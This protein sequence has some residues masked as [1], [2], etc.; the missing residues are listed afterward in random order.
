M[1]R[2]SRGGC[3]VV[4][5]L[6]VLREVR[7]LTKIRSRFRSFERFRGATL[8]HESF[9]R[10]AVPGGAQ[11]RRATYPSPRR[12]HC[13]R[14]CANLYLIKYEIDSYALRDHLRRAGRG[15]FARVR[16]RRDADGAIRCGTGIWSAKGA[17][18]YLHLR[19]ASVSRISGHVRVRRAFG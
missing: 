1:C 16:D 19:R 13:L 10:G 12:L 2:L 8:D 11:G 6:S 3:T 14:I 17:A 9:S 18:R 4:C 5:P 7:G 15:A